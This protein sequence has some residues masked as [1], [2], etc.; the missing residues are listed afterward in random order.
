MAAYP[1]DYNANM[2]EA[3]RPS[4]IVI[5][6]LRDGHGATAVAAFSTRARPGAPVSVPLRWEELGSATRSDRFTVRNVAKR[7]ASI[8]NDPWEGIKSLRQTLTG[9][10]KKLQDIAH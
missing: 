8:K 10:G 7:L 2:S 3:A 1:A 4:K 9:P 6:Y 5:D